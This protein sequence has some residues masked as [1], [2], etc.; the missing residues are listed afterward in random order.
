[1]TSLTFNRFLSLAEQAKVIPFSSSGFTNKRQMNA[2]RNNKDFRTWIASDPFKKVYMR[3]DHNP[4]FDGT[5]WFSNADQKYVMKYDLSSGG[6]IFG[7]TLYIKKGNQ[8]NIV[9]TWGEQ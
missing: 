3:R 8:L 9:K 2:I 6:K 7:Y 5:Y 1:M 4:T